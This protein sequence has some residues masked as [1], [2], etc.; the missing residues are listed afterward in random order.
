MAGRLEGKVCPI[1]TRTGAGSAIPGGGGRW[2]A[3][4]FGKDTED[5]FAGG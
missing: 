5:D 4:T 3:P 1:L 2:L